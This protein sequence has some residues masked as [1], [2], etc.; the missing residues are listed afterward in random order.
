ML[1][2]LQPAVVRANA[3]FGA[4]YSCVTRRVSGTFAPFR[5]EPL[6]LITHNYNQDIVDGDTTAYQAGNASCRGM[7]VQ[8]WVDMCYCGVVISPFTSGA[9]DFYKDAYF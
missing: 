9:Y 6:R 1:S 8:F 3:F 5:T 4:N 2:K 7:E